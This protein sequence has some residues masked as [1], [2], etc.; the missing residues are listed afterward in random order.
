MT[1]QER[2]IS[3][4]SAQLAVCCSLVSSIHSATNNDLLLVASTPISS[5]FILFIYSPKVSELTEFLHVTFHFHHVL[6]DGFLNAPCVK[7]NVSF[8]GHAKSSYSRNIWILMTTFNE[9]SIENGKW[10]QN[11]NKYEGRFRWK[12]ILSEI[13]V[14]IVPNFLWS[15]NSLNI[16][17]VVVLH[18]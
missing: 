5:V 3:L 6:H 11:K 14:N 18:V 7:M 1:T 10:G 16:F 17:A 15:F 13:V 8:Q 4:I 9:V 12:A 2:C